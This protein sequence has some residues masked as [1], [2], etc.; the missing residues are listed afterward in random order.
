MVLNLE[1]KKTIITELLDIAHQ[2]AS[3]VVVDYRGVTVSEMSELRKMARNA[4][5]TVRVYRNTLARR[6]FKETPYACLDKV[7]TGPIVLFFSSGDLGAA[8][9]LIEKFI[10]EHERLTVK[11]LALRGELLPADRLT[12]VAKLSS[13]E[14]TLSQLAAVLLAPVIRFVRM[15]NEPMAQVVRVMSAIQDQRKT[16]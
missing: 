2:A 10:K 9:R 14:E 16:T 5:V 11:A 6:A 3:V 15:L 7:L 1:Q 12:V 8:A 4:E 13:R